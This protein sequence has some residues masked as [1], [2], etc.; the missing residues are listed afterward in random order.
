MTRTLQALLTAAALL[1]GAATFSAA[2]ASHMGMR[3]NMGMRGNMGMRQHMGLCGDGRMM[4]RNMRGC[5]AF[6][7]SRRHQIVKR[8]H[9][10][11][12]KSY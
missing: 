9:R 5:A 2:Q 8:H 4:N 1:I 10:M 12:M 11:M 6:G 3:D 7:H